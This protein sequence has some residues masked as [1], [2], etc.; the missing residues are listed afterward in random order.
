MMLLILHVQRSTEKHLLFNFR[1]S[2]FFINFVEILCVGTTFELATL[3]I[4]FSNFFT[5]TEAKRN[6]SPSL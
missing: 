4:S 2:P 1:K 5:S 3:L 6:L